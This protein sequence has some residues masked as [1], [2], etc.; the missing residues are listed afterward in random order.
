MVPGQ[1]FWDETARKGAWQGENLD[2]G[3]MLV[4]LC[5]ID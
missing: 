1:S 2:G 5:A 4:S 3:K